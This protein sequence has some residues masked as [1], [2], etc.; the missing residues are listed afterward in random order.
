MN[1]I[2]HEDYKILSDELKASEAEIKTLKANENIIR[3]TLVEQLGL[4][5]MESLKE[6]GKE[7]MEWLLARVGTVLRGLQGAVS[8]RTELV[9]TLC[10]QLGIEAVTE[11]EIDNLLVQRVADLVQDHKVLRQRLDVVDQ[12]AVQTTRLAEV[13]SNDMLGPLPPPE[14]ADH[15][16]HMAIGTFLAGRDANLYEDD[17]GT[18]YYA[19]DT[20]ISDRKCAVAEVTTDLGYTHVVW[21][22]A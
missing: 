9:T 21:F 1:S 5:G 13:L 4:T 18:V 11:A 2:T 19:T 6:P 8:R 22:N 7:T 14:M 12:S 3:E 17:E 10:A 16:T 20:Q 15:C